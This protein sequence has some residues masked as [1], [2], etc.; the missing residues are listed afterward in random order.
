MPDPSCLPYYSPRLGSGTWAQ[1]PENIDAWRRG[2]LLDV[3]PMTLEFAP[4][5]A[6]NLNCP[7]C[8][9]AYAHARRAADGV[10][11]PRGQYARLDDR[12]AAKPA[13]AKC[14]L[15]RSVEAGVRGIIWTGGGEPTIYEF[16]AEMLRYGAQ[17]GMVN[18][19]YTNGVQLGLYPAL[20]TDLLAVGTS[21]VFVRVSINAVSPKAVR[22]HWGVRDPEDV[23]PQLRGL[24][25]LFRARTQL[26]PQFQLEHHPIPSIQVSTIIDEKNVDDLLPICQTV[27]Q[28]VG[29]HSDCSGDEDVM[30]VRPLTNHR[31]GLYSI[32]DH[33]DSVIA[34]ILEVCG[35]QG[36]GRRLVTEAGMQ[37]FL[38][39][40][41]DRVESGEAQSYA[42]VLGREYATRD[43]CWAN[44]LF[45]TVGPDASVHLCT[46]HNCDPNWAVGNLKT[47]SVTGV[48]KGE[49]R[50]QLLDIVHGVRMGPSAIEP[51]TRASRLDRIAKAIQSGVLTDTQI[52][53]IRNA[54]LNDPPLLLS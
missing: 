31:T 42:E 45:L 35:R 29:K 14:V 23:T 6:C 16:L 20:A 26:L 15:D 44:G 47:Q 52:E 3:Q 25:E 53:A 13:T 37:L 51:N 41:L 43:Y 11:V 28:I 48:Y 17:L 34:H 2:R 5:V 39:F 54:S 1:R 12:S 32:D 22:R 46:E 27:A 36:P 9:S 38:G 8:P 24:D 30:I 33:E 7:G 4:I 21:V 10:R 49:R 50:R 40:G 19:L 18:C